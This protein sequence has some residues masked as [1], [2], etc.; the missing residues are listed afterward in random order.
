MSIVGMFG[1]KK[2]NIVIL[3]DD[4][5]EAEAKPTRA[6]IVAAMGRLVRDA[7]PNDS[8]FFHCTQLT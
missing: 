4:A 7:S 5:Y 3:T 8:L 6:N 2:E 1:Y